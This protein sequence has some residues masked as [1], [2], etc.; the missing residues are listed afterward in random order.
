MYLINLYA[1]YILDSAQSFAGEGCVGARN[2]ASGVPEAALAWSWIQSETKHQY[3]HWRAQ[4][5]PFIPQMA[6]GAQEALLA[7]RRRRE[8]YKFQPYYYISAG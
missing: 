3:N 2:Y 1:K 4:W 8:N 7:G 6:A 5:L